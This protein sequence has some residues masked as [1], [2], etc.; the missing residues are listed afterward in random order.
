M[1]CQ[2]LKGLNVA[3]EKYKD[4]FGDY[5]ESLRQLSSPPMHEPAASTYQPFPFEGRYASS[6]FVL[7]Y[8]STQ[9][10]GSKHLGY[11]IHADPDKY[12]SLPHYYVHQTK[13][14]PYDPER[15][16]AHSRRVDVIAAVTT[17]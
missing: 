8:D 9:P 16:T 12:P 4:A 1:I 2:R 3:L 5:P 6:Y 7:T 10:V 15:A 13:V 14:M 11:E 17:N